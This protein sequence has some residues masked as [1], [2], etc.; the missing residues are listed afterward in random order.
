MENTNWEVN[1]LFTKLSMSLFSANTSIPSLINAFS[2]FIYLLW[3][4]KSN[5]D[6]RISTLK[7]LLV[8]FK[9]RFEQMPIEDFRYILYK[10]NEKYPVKSLTDEHKIRFG[11]VQ[12]KA[13]LRIYFRHADFTKLQI[14]NLLDDLY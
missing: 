11:I 10:A 5:P 2:H 1:A 6:Q 9:K 13:V 8:L 4:T 7:Y 12:L 14:D 3:K